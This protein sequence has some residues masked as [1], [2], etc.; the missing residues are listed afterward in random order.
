[1][2][3]D[4]LPHLIQKKIALPDHQRYSWTEAL[5]VNTIHKLSYFNEPSLEKLR[6]VLAKELPELRLPERSTTARNPK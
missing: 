6:E 2:V 3:S 5:R 4:I 1:M